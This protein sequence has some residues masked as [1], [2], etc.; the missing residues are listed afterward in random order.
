MFMLTDKVAMIGDSAGVEV[1]A[2]P[3][4]IPTPSPAVEFV[5]SNGPVK[6]VLI[7]NQA[8]R[9]VARLPTGETVHL[10]TSPTVMQ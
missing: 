3:T 9:L 6:G 1:L 10:Y 7:I 8:G 4:R 2:S 5:V